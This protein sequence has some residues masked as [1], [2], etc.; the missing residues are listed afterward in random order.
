LIS[1]TKYYVRAY[2]IN[3]DGTGYG[4]KD[5][6]TTNTSVDPTISIVGSM[7][8]FNACSGFES[9]MDSFTVSGSNLTNSI[10]I[11]APTGFEISSDLA[12]G[13]TSSLS[14]TQITGLVS[15]TKIYV[16]LNSSASGTPSGNIVLSSTGATTQNV[17]A[18]GTVNAVPTINLGAVSSVLVSA[19]SFSLPY[20]GTTGNPNKYSIATGTPTAMPSF[21]AVNNATLGSSPISV[22]I[23]ASAANTYN[24]N[25][26]VKNSTT[27]CNSS[28]LPFA[29][30]VGNPQP[31]IS[32]TGAPSAF[33]SCSGSPS[34]VDSI[35]V[36]GSFL[37]ANLTITAPTD[38][39][40]STT[41]G[42]GYGSSVSLAP[43][44][45]TVAYTAI[46]V[47]L[48]S[49]A[50]GTPTGNIICAS[51]GATTINVA[52][53]GTVNANPA[54]I[55]PTLGSNYSGT[56]DGFAHL[57]TVTVGVGETAVWYTTMGGATS[58][59]GLTN[60][61][62]TTT[63]YAA[64]RITAT[65]CESSSRTS[66]DVTISPKALTI[67][68]VNQAKCEGSNF[69]FAGTEFISS[70]LVNS[71]TLSSVTI[72]CGASGIGGTNAGSPYT[73]EPSAAIGSGLSNYSINYVNGNFTVWS[74]P[75]ASYTVTETSGG[76]NNDNNI[77]SGATV[78]FNGSASSF[79][80]GASSLTYQ[81]KRD[82]IN[83]PGLDATN[84]IYA[85]FVTGINN[86]DQFVYH[87]VVTNNH[88]CT[89]TPFL[90]VTNTTINIYPSATPSI[91][92]PV[93]GTQGN[94]GVPA[95]NG[96]GGQLLCHSNVIFGNTTILPTG[97]STIVYY[98]WSYG[99]SSSN[100]VVTTTDNVKHEYPVN[101]NINWF[102]AA[103][104]NTRY[105][106]SLT[107]ITNQ[108]CSITTTI[109]RDVKNGPDAIIG[110]ADPTTQ[111]LVGNSFGFG[112]ISDNN[113]P[114]FIGSSTWDWGDG[115]GTSNTTFIPKV[116]SAAGSYR[117]HLIN[118]TGTGCTDTAY[119]DLTVSSPIAATFTTT[120]NTCGSKVVG[121]TSTSTGA[122][123]YSWNFGDGSPADITANP[124]HTYAADGA[125]I[126]TLTIN[127]SIASTPTTIYVVSNPVVG[128]IVNGGPSACGNTYSFSNVSTGVNLSYA[129]TFGGAASTGATSTTS[130][131]SRIYSVAGA[132]TVDL[133]VSADG[134]CPVSATQL[135]F[136]SVIGGGSPAAGVSIAAASVPSAT[137]ISVNN[138]S[139]NGT[140]Y[141]VS[142][143][144][145]AFV[146]KTVFPYDIIGLTNGS[147][148]VRLVASD[149]LGTCIDTATT[150]FT[151]TSTPCIAVAGINTTPSTTQTLA[152]NRFDFFNTT[153]VNGF[154]W[155]SA[156]SWDFGDGTTSTNTHIYGKTYAA[157]GTYTVTLV[158]T[159][160][161]GGCT[162]TATQIVTVT[163]PAA[164]TF[165]TTPNTCG[166]KEV[167]FI[168]TSTGATSYS[169][170]F[171]DG[172]PLDV[173]SNPSHTYA[174]DGAYTVTLTINGSV[175]STS[176]TIYVVSNPVVGS[177]V[178]GGPGSCG[179]SYTFTNSST[180]INLSY[181]W[182][183]DGAASTGATTT[184][185][186]ATR[187][188]SA[189]GAATVDLIVSADGRC[190]V[191][192]TQLALTSVVGTTR[193]IASVSNGPASVPSPTSVAITNSSTNAS[194]FAIS[195]DGAAFVTQLTYPYDLTGLTNGSHSV[196]LVAADIGWT[197]K[198]TATTTFT[199]T[200][201]PC[202]AV[203]GFNITPTSTQP[204]ST[205]KFDFFNTTVHN[206]FG[207]ITS[208]SWDFGDGT[209]NTVNTFVY[210]K[211]Y[212]SAGT[213]N[214]TLTAVSSTGC[215][216]TATKV[217][218]ISASATSSFSYTQPSCG[219][220]AVPFDGSS[221]TSATTYSWNFGDGSSSSNHCKSNTYL[222]NSR[223]LYGS[224]NY[225]WHHGI[226]TTNSGY[227]FSPNSSN[228]YTNFKYL[229]QYLYL[230]SSLN[231]WC[232]L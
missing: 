198:D 140:L 98:I 191:S 160:S 187:I 66:G 197:C 172:S 82:G 71:D 92:T 21:T 118:Y 149:L 203:A 36:S 58:S 220:L 232:N 13:F 39:E 19:T 226:S 122:T 55:A 201:T 105:T 51:T 215:T 14:L 166:S 177:I 116:Y 62:A 112:N 126:V 184:T 192:A 35:S 86:P 50:S 95:N 186:S 76:A 129:W 16:R 133:I 165:T 106:V 75:T 84:A 188:Y 162:S 221:S 42:S 125:Y 73:I 117:V 185:S 204:L 79:G 2:A 46:Y 52:A 41:L 214:V 28:V 10:D 30:T 173:T 69:T 68:A 33:A 154:G 157:A 219:V 6:F 156:N 40:V 124:S 159:M 200:T 100:D 72:T 104:P 132:A 38:F 18:S 31:T 143:D 128:T 130:T 99:D 169:W 137:S 196:R 12:F 89:S 113:H 96:N 29:L 195:I 147:H 103:F 45:G 9:A 178:N 207:W 194:L 64:S 65:G 213:Y 97:G 223:K 34:A 168:S 4:I 87:L 48:T 134:R 74:N 163:A 138:T 59:T 119:L 135:G 152:T 206:G 77:C 37:T 205:N 70:G 24:F 81:W 209:T 127:G 60:V 222:C 44:S 217:V 61:S 5:S 8:A 148:T 227:R 22:A 94:Y 164:A 202:V 225:Q 120:P 190:P 91:S 109:N 123:S 174:A 158:A 115:T 111:D 15:S 101:R 90:P 78:T 189:A 175:A 32:V 146:A 180:G 88:G 211:T 171:G 85:P 1:N 231:R 107:A 54:P 170:N 230:Y 182:T 208:Y 11:S 136:T 43:L 229:W 114:S 53:S 57:P 23:P 110:L 102:D 47:R 224:I 193:P 7:A 26:T 56:Y 141:Y 167:G 155:I 228:D 199:I 3:G 151:I 216:S 212:A 25:L 145:A 144:G 218:T 67:T 153:T 131:A 121:F 93:V 210:G 108:G 17:A 161:P 83:A 150:T 176:T 183:F 142:L 49:S 80:T 179:N 139:T 181:A 63:L 27:G 20:S